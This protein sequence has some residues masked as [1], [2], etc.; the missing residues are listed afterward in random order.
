MTEDRET[1]L[2]RMRMRCWRR[3][4]KEMDMILGPYADAHLAGMNDEELDLLDDLLNENDQDLYRWVSGVDRAP[5]RFAALIA[6]L[7]DFAGTR[8]GTS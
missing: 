5:A 7:S 3:G 8:H 2:R 4:T 1:R 6:R